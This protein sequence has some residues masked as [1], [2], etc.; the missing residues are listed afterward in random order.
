M[1]HFNALSLVLGL[2]WYIGY[3]THTTVKIKIIKSKMADQNGRQTA[4]T[5]ENNKNHSLHHFL[6]NIL[7]QELAQIE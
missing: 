7:L 1:T 6:S 3:L 2:I 4:N 5:E